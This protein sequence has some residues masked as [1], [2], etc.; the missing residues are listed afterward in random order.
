[1]FPHVYASLIQVMSKFMAASKQAHELD[2]TRVKVEAKIHDM[3]K[4]SS[5]R[6]GERMK[7]EAE[8][9]ELKNLV[10]EL[11]RDKVEEDTCLDH[12]QNQN[13]ELRPS[14]SQSKDEVLR[15]FKSFKEFI[16]LLDANYAMGF[17]DFCMDTLELFLEVDFDPIKLRT[18][19]E[20]FLLQMSSR[21]LNID[22]NAS[23]PLLAKDGSKFGGDVLSG[24]SP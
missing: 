16:D 1:M 6:T 11:R 3:E 20:S 2:H 15:D 8:V 4:E 12:L 19:A 9:A 10:E 23:T 5:H 21:D 22:D 18:A 24:L 17:E 14:L 7:L 13:E